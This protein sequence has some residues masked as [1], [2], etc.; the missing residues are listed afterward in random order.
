MRNKQNHT[1]HS[2]QLLTHI[3][4][5]NLN[6]FIIKKVEINIIFHKTLQMNTL[7]F[8]SKIN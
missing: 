8:I 7:H 6:R 2:F 3:I 1:K 4:E 5:E